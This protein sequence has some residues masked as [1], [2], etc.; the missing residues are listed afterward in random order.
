MRKILRWVLIIICLNLLLLLIKPVY[1]RTLDISITCNNTN[2]KTYYDG[3]NYYYLQPDGIYLKS[4]KNE[5][6]ISVSNCIQF[7]A[8]KNNIYCLTVNTDLDKY[9]LKIFDTNSLHEID[10]IYFSKPEYP[11]LL[12]INGQSL[13][14][15]Y[16]N[17]KNN[18][19]CSSYDIL[20]KK[21]NDL[22]EEFVNTS[23][24]SYFN[25]NNLFVAIDNS[26]SVFSQQGINKIH[27]NYKFC[28]EMFGF[29]N[30]NKLLYTDN[31]NINN[32]YIYDILA[33]ELTKSKIPYNSKIK[34]CEIQL[35]YV[36][37]SVDN[38]I[39]VGNSASPFF[40]EGGD[41]N[42]SNQLKYHNHDTLTIFN[43]ENLNIIK[44]KSFKTFERIL[45][46]DN[47]KAITYY[48]G[49][50]L[51]YD[52]DNWDLICKLSADEIKNGGSYT[53]ETCGD[54][55]FVFDDNTGELINRISI[56]F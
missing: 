40:M 13:I 29:V 36:D 24:I 18:I 23:E 28:T 39:L 30:S 12:G 7:V 34:N 47:E 49:K 53:F 54:Y 46:V 11:R 3:K 10:K 5:K 16:Y 22:S 55:I 25:N 27:F 56:D 20:N 15:F 21:K 38:F 35:S 26:K 33:D 6:L 44:E 32:I 48:N 31:T 4:Y 37:K 17:N 19:K 1:R 43:S 41:F 9:I 51:F 14:Y 45:Y 2:Q 8:K 42:S 50:Y 52:S